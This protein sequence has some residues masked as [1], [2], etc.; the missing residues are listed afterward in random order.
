M[1]DVRPVKW[2][3]KGMAGLA[4]M[5]LVKR[6]LWNFAN[7]RT[8]ADSYSP[9]VSLLIDQWRLKQLGRRYRRWLNTRQ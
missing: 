1:A 4:T 8:P 2:R 5:A 7:G 3:D 6:Y 9:L